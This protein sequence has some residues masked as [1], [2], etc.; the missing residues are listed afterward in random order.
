MNERVSPRRSL[1]LKVMFLL[2]TSVRVVP[3]QEIVDGVAAIV[4]DNIILKSDLA[5]LLVRSTLE[6]QL[7]PER[8]AD[9]ILELQDELLESLISRNLMLEIAEAETIVVQDREV[10]AA[11]DQYVNSL[12]AQYGSE[13][14]LKQVAGTSVREL[15]RE[16]WPDMRDQL[17]TQ[18]FQDE[19]L[20][21]IAVTRNEVLAF[22]EEYKDSLRALP[23]LYQLSHILFNVMPGQVSR[24]GAYDLIASLRNR[25]TSGEDFAQLAREFSQDPGSADQGGELGLVTRGTL[26]PLFEEVAF[27]LKPG[28]TSPI[29]ETEFGYHIIQTIGKIGQKINVR[30]IL[31][32]PV[33]S[34]ADEDSVYSFARSIQDSIDTSGDFKSFAEKF[35]DDQTSKDRGGNLGWIDAS[36]LPIPE[37]AEVLPSLPVGE[38]SPP[39]RTGDGYH[40]ILIHAIRPGGDPT[41]SSHW[42]ELEA[43]TL[44]KKKGDFFADWIGTV[45]SSVYI[46]NALE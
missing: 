28:E 19:L 11:V 7:H 34:D 38:T 45:S 31:I 18:R 44:A 33:L 16:L 21:D 46:H 2:L 42:S 32:I 9:Q 23:T 20:K 37:I 6:L 36:V 14:R 15:R 3:A 29:I 24:Q 5:Q 25:L 1:F 41:L 43:L 30:H 35:S 27:S 4:G 8:D 13:D 10:D 40:I 17:I 22:Y 12:V 39:V 26:V